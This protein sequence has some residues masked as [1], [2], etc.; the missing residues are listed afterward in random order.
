MK[1]QSPHTK[2]KPRFRF[3]FSFIFFRNIFHFLKQSH[4]VCGIIR[5]RE[6][7]N[8]NIHAVANVMT[9][10]LVNFVAFTLGWFIIKYYYIRDTIGESSHSILSPF[11]VLISNYTFVFIVHICVTLCNKRWNRV[12]R[13]F[14]FVFSKHDNKIE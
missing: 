3:Q 7:I 12:E 2:G 5:Q 4:C 1:R 13:F 8:I 6:F 14:F 9:R 11:C 10:T